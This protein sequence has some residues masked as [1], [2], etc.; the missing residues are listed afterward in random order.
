MQI[1]A[2]LCIKSDHFYGDRYVLDYGHY[3]S[4]NPRLFSHRNAFLISGTSATC[5]LVDCQVRLGLY[6][7][8]MDVRYWLN[9]LKRGSNV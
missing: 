2:Y 6:F 4:L 7:S 1:D 8:K 9:F 3:S 5:I